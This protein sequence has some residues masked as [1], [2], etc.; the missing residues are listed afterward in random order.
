ME[1]KNVWRQKEIVPLCS[2]APINKAFNNNIKIYPGRET[3]RLSEC[4]AKVQMISKKS[5]QHAWHLAL[6]ESMC[7]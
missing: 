6:Q 2:S 4:Q 5:E 3:W 7:R 1:E